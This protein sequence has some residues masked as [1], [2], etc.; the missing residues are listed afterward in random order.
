MDNG[1]IYKDQLQQMLSAG[2]RGRDAEVNDEKVELLDKFTKELIAAN[3]TVNLTAITDPEEIADKL[4]LDSIF[5]GQ[6]IPRSSAI[7]DLGTGA[8]FPGIPL[9]IAYPDFFVTL[10]D[11][12]RKK[13]NFL[14][15]VIRQLRLKDIEARHIR[16]EELTG[17]GK[18]FDVVITR[19][20]SPL[21]HLIKLALPLLE[22]DGLFVAM[23]GSNYQAEIDSLRDDAFIQTDKKKYN[24]RKLGIEVETYRL[25]VSGI[26]RA[27]IMVRTG[28]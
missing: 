8:G 3:Q 28:R 2:N 19:A 27:L 16:A 26:A 21:D 6:F 12:K 13:V 9:K 22:K 7:L 1:I 11:G 18:R 20:V 15:Y 23:K 17:Q 4:I 25:P 10:I 24:T 5:P 14:K